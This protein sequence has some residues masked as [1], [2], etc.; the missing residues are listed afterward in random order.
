MKQMFCLIFLLSQGGK[1]KHFLAGLLVFLL[2]MLDTR[3]LYILL[4]K[5]TLAGINA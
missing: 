2:N 4:A 3:L 5:E 1:N